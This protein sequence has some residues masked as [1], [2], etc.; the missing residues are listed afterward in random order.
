MTLAAGNNTYR[1]NNQV[2]VEDTG[3][4]GSGLRLQFQEDVY[5]RY[6]KLE[7]GASVVLHGHFYNPAG[8]TELCSFDVKCFGGD[9]TECRQCAAILEGIPYGGPKNVPFPA[10]EIPQQGKLPYFIIKPSA[11]GGFGMVWKVTKMFYD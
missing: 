11:N 10:I 1:C 7:L 8:R 2:V 5:E 9:C 4:Y 6:S 3:K